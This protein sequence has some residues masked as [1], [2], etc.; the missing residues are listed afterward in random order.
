MLV[1]SSPDPS[2]P[3]KVIYV[4]FVSGAGTAWTGTGDPIESITDTGATPSI[5]EEGIIGVARGSSSPL[6]GL[7]I[8]YNLF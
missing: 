4:P 1:A 8:P 3:M 5:G 6:I 7:K 2:D